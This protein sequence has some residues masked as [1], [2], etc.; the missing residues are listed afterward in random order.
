MVK[1]FEGDA[2]SILSKLHHYHTQSNDAQHEVVTLTIISPILVS[3]TVGKEQPDNPSEKNSLLDSLVPDT[4]MIPETVRI[5]FLQRAV[6][7]N[8]DLSQIHVLDS[9]WRSRTGSTGKFTF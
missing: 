4:D 3:L 2:G 8:H 1:E 7:Q 6:Q 5:T 9:V